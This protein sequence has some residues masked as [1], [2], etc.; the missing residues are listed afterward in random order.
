MMNPDA[1]HGVLYIVSEYP[2][3]KHVACNMEE[4]AVE[5]HGGEKRH[6]RGHGAF[7]HGLGMEKPRGNKGKRGDKGLL[8]LGSEQRLMKEDKNIGDEEEHRHDG[9]ALCGIN[10][11][12]GYQ[13]LTP[14]KR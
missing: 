9:E 5:K 10:V 13:T 14:S 1:A 2:E 3:V 7:R 8:G 6:A 4:A 12:Y 11:F